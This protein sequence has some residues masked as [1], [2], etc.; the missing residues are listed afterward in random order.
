MRKNK[1]SLIC[2]ICCHPM[3]PKK[4]CTL[5]HIVVNGKR[6]QRAKGGYAP[7]FHKGADNDFICLDC[8][9]GVYQYHHL[10]CNSEMCP[11]CYGRLL[12]CDCDKQPKM[13]KS[14][15]WLWKNK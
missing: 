1:K 8:K 2:A 9:V 14:P 12:L 4:E 11:V 3:E 6:Y 5:S 10:G 7:D 13:P 15:I